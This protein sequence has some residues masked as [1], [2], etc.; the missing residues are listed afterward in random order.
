MTIFVPVPNPDHPAGVGGVYD[1]ASLGQAI[2]DWFARSDIAGY[3]DYFIQKAEQ[4]IYR[5]I[6]AMNRGQGVRA[7]ESAIS[8][9]ISA[10]GTLALPS[11]YL[12]IKY[13]LVGIDGRTFMLERR[14]AEF[15]YTQ[16]PNRGPVGTPAYVARDGQNFVF[17][18]AP[19]SEYTITGVYWQQAGQL[20]P[21]NNV[22]WMTETIPTI[23]LAA[24]CGAVARF[25]NDTQ[26]QQLWDAE[27]ISE[28]RDFLDADRAEEQSGSAFAMVSA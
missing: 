1:Y 11:G 16:F 23:L 17:G 8:T 27:Y 21:V 4:K 6:F 9:T 28:M 3:V 7:I 14:N 22:T 20:T 15:I 25:L 12:G 5:D 10:S 26:R 18:P 13:L 24:C 2:Q 19:D